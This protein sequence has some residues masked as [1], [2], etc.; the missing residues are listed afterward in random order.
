MELEVLLGDALAATAVGFLHQQHCVAERLCFPEFQQQLSG[1]GWAL[2]PPNLCAMALISSLFLQPPPIP[3]KTMDVFGR[4]G[5]G[6][7]SI[8][9]HESR[10]AFGVWTIYLDCVRCS[11][12][13]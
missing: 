11:T 2:L 7:R 13:L 3:A 10:V 8:C 4:V 6:F 12:R 5:T 1:C 9:S